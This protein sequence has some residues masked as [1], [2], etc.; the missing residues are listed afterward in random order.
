MIDT[1]DSHDAPR[2]PPRELPRAVTTAMAL[3]VSVLLGAA[4]LSMVGVTP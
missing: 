4:T 3:A 2:Q 1:F